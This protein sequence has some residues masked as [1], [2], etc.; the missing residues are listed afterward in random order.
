VR[1]I[2]H[3]VH[4]DDKGPILAL[5]VAAQPHGQVEGIGVQ[6]VTEHI[7]I[8]RQRAAFPTQPVPAQRAPFE[9]GHRDATPARGLRVIDVARQHETHARLVL[10]GITVAHT[11]SG[12]TR[13][14]ERV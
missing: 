10:A 2:R 4:A 6:P 12:C 9:V 13:Q 3:N 8:Q 7:V 14:S 5:P 1:V 11:C